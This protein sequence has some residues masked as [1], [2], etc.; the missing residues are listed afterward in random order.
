MLLTAGV[1]I[2]QKASPVSSPFS[3][4]LPN[5]ADPLAFLRTKKSLVIVRTLLLLLQSG[6]TPL[7]YA[8]K[9]GHTAVIRILVDAGADV[10]ARDEVSHLAQ[11]ISCVAIVYVQPM[12]PGWVDGAYIRSK[13][14]E[15]RSY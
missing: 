3:P 13:R 1:N 5:R 11:M 14:R 12:P 6:C 4:Y 10:N 8:T 7:M 9:N 15:R 2:N